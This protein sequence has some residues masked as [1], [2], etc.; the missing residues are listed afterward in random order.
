M[1]VLTSAL[2]PAGDAYAERRAA[3]LAKLADLDERS[4]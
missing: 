3:M 1:T 2:D 4:R